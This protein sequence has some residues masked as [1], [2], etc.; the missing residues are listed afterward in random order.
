MY[1][2][3]LK[4]GLFV[5]RP[6]NLEVQEDSHWAVDPASFTSGYVCWESDDKKPA[7]KHGEMMRSATAP[8]IAQDELPEVPEG[9]TW[10]SQ[11]GV[12]LLC[13]DGEDKGVTVLYTVTSVGGTRAVNGLI[14]EVLAKVDSGETDKLVA[15]VTLSSDSYKHSRH[16]QIFNPSSRS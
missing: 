11:L 16:G 10:K 1:L 14:G 9:Q 2:R 15:V 3:L 7:H 12:K 13:L 5:F 6:D 8:P 4:T